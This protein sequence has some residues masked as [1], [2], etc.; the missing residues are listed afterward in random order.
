MLRWLSVVALAADPTMPD[1]PHGTCENGA[2]G[3]DSYFLGRFTVA[4]GKVTGTETWVLFA[5][6]AWKAHGGRDCTVVWNVTGST[7]PHGACASCALSIQFHAEPDVAASKCPTALLTGSTTQDGKK[8]SGEA[9]PF[10]QLYDVATQP[11]GSAV[12]TFGKSGKELG[13]GHYAGGVLDYQSVHQCKF[14]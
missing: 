14:F 4:D 10:D 9:V 5:N 7:A 1:L 2:T 8:V 13:R 12:V 11:D 3:A 6:D